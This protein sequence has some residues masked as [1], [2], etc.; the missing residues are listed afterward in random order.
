MEL[1]EYIEEEF[2]QADQSLLEALKD[3][4]PEEIGYCPGPQCNS[5]GFILW[6]LARGED[7]WIQMV[8]LNRPQVWDSEGWYRK[9]NMSSDPMDL[10]YEYTLEQLNAFSSPPIDALLDYYWTV[11]RR[12]LDYLH[13][14]RPEKLN[15]MIRDPWSM[16]MSRGATIAHLLWEL[17]QH[18]GQIAYLRGMQRGLDK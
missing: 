14:L 16:N 5:I 18:I 17:N 6:H 2:R 12:T 15:E 10:G 1:K 9:F 4:T 3:L 7:A 11:R 13:S 8:A